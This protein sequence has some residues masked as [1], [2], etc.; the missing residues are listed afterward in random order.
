MPKF[1][2]NNAEEQRWALATFFESA[3]EILQ[4]EGSTSAIAIPQLF[5]EMLLPNC[6]CNCAIPQSHFFY[7]TQYESFR[8]FRHIFGHGI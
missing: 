7:S 3:I 5:K 4:F 2:K 1:L 6:N 8:I